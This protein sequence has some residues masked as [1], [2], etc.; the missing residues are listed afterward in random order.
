MLLMAEQRSEEQSKAKYA[1][2]IERI[3]GYY[4]AQE[5]PFGVVYQRHP[6]YLLIEC[7]CGE[8]LALTCFI[9]TCSDCGADCAAVVQEELAGQCSEEG[10]ALH[11][12]RYAGEREDVGLPC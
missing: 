9:S 2:I 1:K 3:G 5:V 10:E 4:E 7:G 12:W 6:G 8:R 11:P